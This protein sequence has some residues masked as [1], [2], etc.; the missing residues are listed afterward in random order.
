MLWGW[1][2]WVGDSLGGDAGMQG[3]VV[4]VRD[5]VLFST[6]C[7]SMAAIIQGLTFKG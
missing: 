7:V 1:V 6:R 5:A 4:S 3:C 2:G